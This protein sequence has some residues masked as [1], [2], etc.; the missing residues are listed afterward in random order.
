MVSIEIE[1]SKPHLLIE[2]I[3]YLPN[4]VVNKTIIHKAT[5]NI[6][7]TAIDTG[8]S[9][10]KKASPFDTFI[11]IIDG[12]TVVIIDETEHFLK[13]G[14]ALIIPAHSSHRFKAI[15]RFKM[16]S[17]IIKSGYEGSII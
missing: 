2:M 12:K 14:E 17:T 5:G 15:V 11:Q 10:E 3:Q 13:T 7:V 8:E 16:I 9:L 1:K 6:S 4:S